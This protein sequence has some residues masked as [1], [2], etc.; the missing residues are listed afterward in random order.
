MVQGEQGTQQGMGPPSPICAQVNSTMVQKLSQC[1]AAQKSFVSCAQPCR[2]FVDTVRG[3]GGLL[4]GGGLASSVPVPVLAMLVRAWRPALIP[5][6]A[7]VS[8]R[9]LPACCSWAPTAASPAP[10]RW[11]PTKWT[12]ASETPIS[13]GVSWFPFARWRGPACPAETEQQ[14]VAHTVPVDRG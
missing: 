12:S 11:W 13:V 10:L 6:A 3:V 1:V 7:P 9:L 5:L 8:R 2:E 14:V 4:R